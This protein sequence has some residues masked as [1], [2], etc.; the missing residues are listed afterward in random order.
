[1]RAALEKALGNNPL[2]VS[3]YVLD[4][5]QNPHYVT[6][7][8]SVKLWDLCILDHGSVKTSADVQQMAIQYPYR[9]HAMAPGPLFRCL[10]VHVEET[11]SAAMV[12]YSQSTW[13]YV[14]NPY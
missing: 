14:T 7:R 13:V 6:L 11:K 10:I 9:E 5:Y 3:C 12:M 1:M 4:R 2:L 8:P